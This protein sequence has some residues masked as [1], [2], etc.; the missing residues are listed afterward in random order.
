MEGGTK[1]ICELFASAYI[2]NKHN[3]IFE[4]EP[5]SRD[6]YIFYMVQQRAA[7]CNKNASAEGTGLRSVGT[8]PSCSSLCAHGDAPCSGPAQK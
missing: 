6:N 7:A 1:C 2:P 3:I 4:L 8:E 5:T